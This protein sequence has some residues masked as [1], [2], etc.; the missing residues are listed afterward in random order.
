MNHK[1][2]TT[3]ALLIAIA[4]TSANAATVPNNTIV[5]DINNSTGSSQVSGITGNIF[6]KSS[7]CFSDKCV[8]TGNGSTSGSSGNNLSSSLISGTGSFNFGDYG[9]VLGNNASNTGLFGV[10]L[11]DGTTNTKDFNVSVGGRTIGDV[12]NATSSD[13]AV[14]L[15]QATGLV[16]TAQTT[17]ISAAK[18][19]TDAQAASTDRKSVV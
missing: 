15:G 18:A 14:N 10:A 5:V 13:Q 12:L 6:G 17:A 19:Y 16:S 2:K 9:V 7:F 4:F 8:I 11:G 3:L 1:K